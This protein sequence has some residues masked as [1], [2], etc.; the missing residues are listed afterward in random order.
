VTDTF[1]VDSLP[2]TI[3]TDSFHEK[4]RFSGSDQY[5]WKDSAIKLQHKSYGM[6]EYW[7]FTAYEDAVTV[8]WED[9]TAYHLL[10]H[11]ADGAAV[12]FVFDVP[13]KH[14]IPTNQYVYVESVKVWY[15]NGSKTRCFSLSLR[16]I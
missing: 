14:T 5:I 7:T 1:T 11:V 8:E 9:S 2:L 4:T 6:V 12:I 16:A 15:S 13:T 10:T 3:Q